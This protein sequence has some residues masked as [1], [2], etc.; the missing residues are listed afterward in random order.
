MIGE[1]TNVTGSKKF[2]R[3]IT[4]GDYTAA[5]D[6]ALDQVRGGANILDVNM[7]EGMLDS[8]QAMTTFLNLI[9]TEPEIARVPVMV[10]SSKWSVIEAGLKCVQGKGVVN[11]ISLKE[12]EADFLHKARLV[13]RYGAGVVV[14]AFDEQGQADTVERKVAICQRAYK[15][16]TEQVGFEPTDIIFDPNILAVATGIEEHNDYAM[17]FIEAARDHQGDA[18][19][20]CTSAAASATC[21]SR[22]AA[23]TSCARRCTRRSCTTPSRPAWTWASSTPASSPS[24]R[25]SRR[26]C[27]SASRTCSSTAGPTRPS[28]WS[29]SP[30]RSRAPARKRDR[31]P[32]WREQPV[33]ERLAHAL[34]HGI[35]D[36][37]EAD[38]EEARQKL[39]RPL[40][41]IEGPLMDGMKVVG[42]LFGAGKMFLP[43]VVKSARV[44]KKA[45]A[46]LEPF[47]EEEKR[48]GGVP[49][50]SGGRR[51]C[52]ATVKGD[53]HDIGKNI[54]GVVLGCNNYE[55][56]RPRRHGAVREDPADGHGEQGVD[57]IGLS[58]LI[59]P[60]LDEMVHVA[61]EMERPGLHDAAADRRRDDQPAAHGGEDRARVSR[62]R[63]C[64]CSTR[65]ARSAW[66]RACSIR[67][68]SDGFDATNRARAGGAARACTARKQREAAAHAA[69]RRAPIALR[70]DWDGLRA[71][72]AGVHRPARASTCRSTDLVPY[73]DWTF[74]FSRLGA[75]GHVPGDPRAPAVRR[76]GA[77]AVRQ[78]ARRCSSASS[79]ERL[80][81]A[82][83]VYGFWPAQRDG[84]DIVAVRRRRRRARG[85]ALP[86]AAAAGSRS[87]TAGR[88]GRWPTS[89][90]RADSG[91]ADYV[92][93]FAVTAGIG[94][95]ELVARASRREHDDYNAIMVKALADRLAEAFAEYLH[96]Q[97]APRLGLRRATSSCRT[98]S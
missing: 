82:R 9:A 17:N 74:F 98:T 13:R 52:M 85:G 73:I 94:A 11:S 21:R 59:T 24:T 70:L 96:A 80:L 57:I 20:A 75:E 50:A 63:R 18:A 53:V 88:T 33:E 58:G 56:D 81:T 71:A 84:D 34:V 43:Q 16:L 22:S 97:R 39:P 15:L 79:R 76:G 78:R 7:D 28:G 90:R 86:H 46:Y 83:G 35:V 41:V 27:S 31:R 38:V 30:T 68:S 32:A 48:A 55:V 89:S 92:G 1:R 8:E 44:M 87:P 91:V 4:G 47:M 65:R 2:A 42:D 61:R 67:R 14:M 45:V 62:Q 26:T 3:L 40:D 10:D 54:V 72:G 36:F 93:A 37:I 69:P 66:C 23:T 95:D 29:S 19:R 64:T 25:T 77:R 51:S 6:V 12:G 60:S 5:V 49:S